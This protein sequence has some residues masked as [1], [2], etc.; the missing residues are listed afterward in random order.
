MPKARLT[1]SVIDK[2]PLAERGQVT[3]CDEDLP[4]FYL[5]VGSRA[6]TYAAQKDIRGRSVR[7]TIGRH[8]HF[9]PEEARKI[10]KDKLYLMAQGINPNEQEAQERAKAVT[11]SLVL[12]NYIAMRKGLK[13]RTVTDYRYHVDHYLSD[14][15]DKLMTDITKDM[16][17][18]RHVRIAE[19][20]GKV[21]ANKTMRI[22]RALFNHCHAT[23]DICPANP[24]KYLTYTKGWYKQKRRRTYIKPQDLK[25]WW[26]AVHALENDTYRDYFLI[27]LFTGMRRAEAAAL[28]WVDV[29][30]KDRT[31]TIP[32][33]KNGDPL[34]LPMSDYL[35]QL[36]QRRFQKYG[37][38]IFV[39]PGPGKNGFLAEPKKGVYKV[40]KASGI[41]FTCHDLRR[42]FITI[43]E[44]LDISTY[45]M[46]R[47]INHR[48]TDITGGYIIVDVERLR[49]PVQR[50]AQYIEEQVNGRKIETED[51]SR[52]GQARI[53][54]SGVA[55]V[56][57]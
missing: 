22:V 55:G 5:I 2:L 36:F 12:E 18:A 16:I 11:L 13:P 35:H 19:N 49:A 20:H 17:G 8:G 4:G 40:I 28:R 48:M 52:N 10:A 47:L 29:D 31:F 25:A 34:T 24:V 39:F 51:H 50:I 27:L 6:K 46:K 7:F 38:G 54:L 42:T 57:G 41:Q 56:S 26:E 14:W 30:F 44:S 9:T 21:T 32:D 53:S 15:K 23:Y 33:T 1:K 37:G 45:S 3:Y 43:A